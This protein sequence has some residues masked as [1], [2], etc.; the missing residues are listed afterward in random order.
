MAP[1]L[2]SNS[3]DSALWNLGKVMQAGVSQ[4]ILQHAAYVGAEKWG[5]EPSNR[6]VMHLVNSGSPWA[7]KESRHLQTYRKLSDKGLNR[8]P[9]KVRKGRNPLRPNVTFCPL[10]CHYDKISLTDKN[11]HQACM[12]WHFYS[13]LNRDKIPPS[14][15]KMKLGWKNQ[16]GQRP[17]SSFPRE[18]SVPSFLPFSKPTCQ[19]N[20]GWQLLTCLPTL[21][22][23][24]YPCL[25]KL[26][27]YFLDKSRN[28]AQVV[29]GKMEKLTLIYSE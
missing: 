13:K 21:P 2:I 22:L 25:N 28:V 20:P 29:C 12:P 10:C 9:R 17:N 14:L 15:S 6:K 1:P 3:L 11:S 23:R 19:R 26:L 18:Y 16:E 8:R 4:E 24:L 7:D 27:L 5:Q